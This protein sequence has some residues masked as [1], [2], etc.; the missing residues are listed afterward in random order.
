MS[1]FLDNNIL[2]NVQYVFLPGKSTHDAVFDTVRHIYSAINQNKLMAIIF[3]DVA[4]A[5]NCIDHKVLYAKLKGVGMSERIIRW[6]NSYLTRSQMVKY[7]DMTSNKLPVTAGIAQ[8]TVLGPLIFV[9]YINDCIQVLN[10]VKL[11]MFADDCMLYYTG[12]NWKTIFDIVQLDLNCFVEWT[13]NNMLRLN[14]TKTQAMIVGTRSRLSKIINP[15][16]F[17]IHANDVKYV[18]SYNYLGIVLDSGQVPLCKNMEKRVVDK[19]FMLRKQI[20]DI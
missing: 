9:F 2:S 15:E 10:H 8:G 4:K 16:P 6:F 18:K 3:L 12:N 20:S 5:F 1:Y 19:I 13:T 11:S 17:K 14:T 7:G